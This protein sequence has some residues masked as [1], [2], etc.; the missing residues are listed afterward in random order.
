MVGLSLALIVTLL[1]AT[2]VAADGPPVTFYE[3]TEHV[4]GWDEVYDMWFSHDGKFL[5]IR[6]MGYWSVVTSDEPRLNASVTAV[7]HRDVNL[8]SEVM[9][10]WGNGSYELDGGAWDVSF[11]GTGWGFP[12]GTRYIGHGAGFG[13]GDLEGQVLHMKV[14]QVETSAEPLCNG[15]AP[16]NSFKLRGF[17][18]DRD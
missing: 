16:L 10:V 13:S 5:H 3:A 18:L 2:G 11:H 12:V 1:L 8:V 9:R 4:C 7:N 6:D 15:N 17:I 14:E